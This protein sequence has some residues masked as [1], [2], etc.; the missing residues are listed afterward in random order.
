MRRKEF[1]IVDE[2][3]IDL[4]LADMSLGFLGTVGEDGWPQ[5]T[6]LN[7]IYHQGSIYFHGSKIGKKMNDIR[8]SNQVTFTVAKQYGVIPSYFSDVN[9]AC[10]AST[11]YKSVIIKG[12]AVI[13]D[14]INEKASVFSSLMNKLQPEG[15]FAPID[16][17]N[18]DYFKNLQA[19]ALVKIK[20][21]E[22]VAKF[23]F[24]QH[25]N[26]ARFEKI[27]TGL[28]ERQEPLDHEIIALMKKYYP[29][30]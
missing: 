16:P 20:L 14:D 9:L 21:V 26:E 13:V 28:E 8:N 27:I 1:E 18:S 3:E 23:K 7:Y 6:P 29:H 24:G 25:L 22:R 10:P 2:T 19:V 30:H 11:F 15:K 17:S 12:Y 4:F 5:V